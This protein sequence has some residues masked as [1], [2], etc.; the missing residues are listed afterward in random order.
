MAASVSVPAVSMLASADSSV[1]GVVLSGEP[2]GLGLD[3]DAGDVVGDHVVQFPGQFEALVPPD[4]LQCLAVQEV[5][6]A[7]IEADG[8]R[9][10]PGRD[11]G[12]RPHDPVVEQSRQARR[13][14]LPRSRA[15]RRCR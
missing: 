8:E 14:R 7:E 5:E 6:V 15:S 2:G 3:D 11:P 10:G 4:R 9:G 13:S 1:P 12:Q